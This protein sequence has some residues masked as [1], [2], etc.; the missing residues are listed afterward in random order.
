M[1]IIWEQ[2]DIVGHRADLKTIVGLPQRARNRARR[3]QTS[4]CNEIYQMA[5][6]FSCERFRVATSAEA[7][8]VEGMKSVMVELDDDADRFIHV[9]QDVHALRG[10]PL[11]TV[12]PVGHDILPYRFK[13]LMLNQTAASSRMKILN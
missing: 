11:L 6:T 8:Y 5:T 9:A 12:A 10:V 1:N 3:Q 4:T 7:L 2:L 13:L